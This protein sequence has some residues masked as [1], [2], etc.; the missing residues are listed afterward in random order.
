MTEYFRTQAGEEGRK[1]AFKSREGC[2]RWEKN[3][4]PD[5]YRNGMCQLEMFEQ[6]VTE[7]LTNRALSDGGLFS[8]TALR[9]VVTGI[10]SV[11]QECHLGGRFFPFF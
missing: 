6:K 9:Y 7:S 1:R 5:L 4:R 2:T 10:D 8:K 3:L 11:A